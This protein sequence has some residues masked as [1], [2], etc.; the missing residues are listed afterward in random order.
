MTNQVQVLETKEYLSRFAERLATDSQFMANVLFQYRQQ[1]RITDSELANHLGISSMMYIRLAMCKR[2][3]ANR[4]NFSDQVKQIATYVGCDSA[5]LAQMINQVDA[6]VAISP[7][8]EVESPQ[9]SI[10]RPMKANLGWLAAARD[11]TEIEQ[12][13]NVKTDTSEDASASAPEQTP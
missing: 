3:L 4:L 5:Q 13:T 1:E 7:A 12:D 8:V 9:E 11:R 6:L 2:P 10:S